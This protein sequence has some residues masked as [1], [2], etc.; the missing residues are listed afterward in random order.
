MRLFEKAPPASRSQLISLASR[1]KTPVLEVYAEKVIASLRETLVDTKRPDADR[2]AA[3]RQLVEFQP[4]SDENASAIVKQLSS[5]SSP[6]LVKGLLEALASGSSKA[7]G[8]TLAQAAASLTPS[9]RSLAL[10]VLS[11]VPIGPP[12][13][14]TPSNRGRSRWGLGP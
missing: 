10:R 4:A 1:W 7:G 3:A 2:V 6:E 12:R 8:A 13:C 9:G 11:A 5:K 14:S